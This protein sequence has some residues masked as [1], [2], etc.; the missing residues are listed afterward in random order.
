MN[1]AMHHLRDEQ[2]TSAGFTLVELAV[3]LVLLGILTTLAAPN[4][5]AYI[6]GTN[7]DRA[8]GELKGDIAY[9]RMLAI[10]SG[11]SAQLEVQSAGTAYVIKVDGSGRDAK[12]VD[13]S[14]D[15]GGVSLA[16]PSTVL[17]FNSRGL[18]VPSFT[19][20]E[21]KITAQQGSS[22]ASLSVLRSGRASRAY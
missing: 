3:V 17:G 18:L 21:I 13:L 1:A 4:M 2:R 6:R 5:A 7:V 8:L 12:R 9:T 22:G 10:R 11:Q 16:P 19:G 15:F 20:D 14:R